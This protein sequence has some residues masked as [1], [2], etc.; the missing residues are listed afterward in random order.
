METMKIIGELEKKVVVSN[1]NISNLYGKFKVGD[2][3]YIIEFYDFG[4]G[5][6]TRCLNRDEVIN[7]IRSGEQILGLKIDKAGRLIED[8][9]LYKVYDDQCDKIKKI[10]IDDASKELFI[11][12]T[13]EDTRCFSEAQKI[14]ASTLGNQN[15]WG[16]HKFVLNIIEEIASEQKLFIGSVY[17]SDELEETYVSKNPEKVIS[18]LAS[19]SKELLV[20]YTYEHD[21]DDI[22]N[23]MEYAQRNKTD[24]PWIELGNFDTHNILDASIMLQT[25]GDV[26]GDSRYGD[27]GVWF[28]KPLDLVLTE[29]IKRAKTNNNTAFELRMLRKNIETFR[30]Y[31]FKASNP[32][33]TFKDYIK[34]AMFYHDEQTKTIEDYIDLVLAIQEI[35]YKNPENIRCDEEGIIIIDK[36][37]IKIERKPYILTVSKI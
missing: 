26:D 15:Y 6:Q 32:Q 20:Q 30:K 12:Y 21:N 23:R 22:K 33:E 19:E 31:D 29:I 4:Y 34:K 14:A 2:N 36:A 9:S 5:N 16:V 1:S 8:Q 25:I 28:N 13:Q 18:S 24:E 7:H 27:N 3:A 35:Y 10:I 11:D 17:L 37:G